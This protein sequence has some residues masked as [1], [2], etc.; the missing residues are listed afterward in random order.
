MS[1]ETRQER[2]SLVAR[3]AVSEMIELQRRIFERQRKIIEKS[4]A[5]SS[6]DFGR[7]RNEYHKAVSGY[8]AESGFGALCD[9]ITLARV[10][11]VADYHTLRLA[12]R[13]FVKLIHGV[14]HQVDN[15]CLAV[16]FVHADFQEDLDRYLR[17]K[18]KESTF[19]RRIQY[20]EQWPY[21]IWPNFKPIF[22]LAIDQGFPV[23]AVDSDSELSLAKR[24]RL[25]ADRI[26]EAAA[27]FP[28]AT[29]LV[30]AGQMHVA[31][32]HLPAAV[33]RA[34]V[35]RGMETP[36]RVI[37]YQN[38]E[39]I[40]WQLARAR[41]EG[42]EVVKVDAES[43]CV[44]NTPPLVQQL[45]YL[46][47]VRFD[48]ELLEFTELDATVR[49][50]IKN[51]GRFLNLPFKKAAREVRVLMPGDLDLMDALEEGGLSEMEIEQVLASVEAEESACIPS[52][53]AIYLATLSV[54]HAAEESAHFLKYSIAGGRAPEDLKD[55]FYFTILNEAAGFFGSKVINPKRKTDHQG[56][57]RQIVAQARKRKGKKSAEER[58]AEFVLEHRSWER[59]N[60]PGRVSAKALASPAVFNAAAHMLGYMLGDRLYYGLTSGVIVKKVIR[61]LFVA[62]LDGPDEALARYLELAEKVRDV[63]IPRRI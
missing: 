17:G 58:A 62:P 30:Y 2:P 16:E 51:L 49:S 10:A 47:W 38:A 35:S 29:I 15:L 12:Q 28:D 55:R 46:H 23:I 50:L 5:H 18:I 34:F 26:A 4:E 52:M 44:N 63:K 36:N 6:R 40:Y 33:D 9:A 1:N 42:V 11:F 60:V 45:S 31:V 13:T 43:Y 56:K 41:R 27:R 24:D 54:N 37:V 39:E 61:D 20:R 59:G 57:L 8:S 22:E 32:P 25:A 19:L 53:G 21:D 3:R 7:Y 48:Q 14:M